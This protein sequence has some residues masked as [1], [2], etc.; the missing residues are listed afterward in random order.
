MNIA[1][2]CTS[3][4]A[5]SSVPF[6]VKPFVSREISVKTASANAGGNI[7]GVMDLDIQINKANVTKK[8]AICIPSHPL[9]VCALRDR[10]SDYLVRRWWEEWRHNIALSFEVV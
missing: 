3:A 10:N 6:T 2:P 5:E 1:L 8:A 7:Q 4:N 9:E